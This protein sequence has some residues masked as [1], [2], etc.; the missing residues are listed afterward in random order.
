M[1]TGRGYYPADVVLLVYLLVTGIPLL[2]SPYSFPGRGDYMMMHFGGLL[3]VSL[4]HFAPRAGHPLWRFV[5]HWYIF[6][7]LPFL[8][9]ALRHLNRLLSLDFF[10][11]EVVRVEEAIFGCQPSQI[12]HQLLPFGSLSEFLHLSYLLYLALIP[13]VGFS[14]YYAGRRAAHREFATT[15]L[16]AYFTCYLLFILLPVR[17]PFHYFGPLDPPPVGGFFASLVHDMLHGASSVGTAFPSS[18]VAAAVAIWLVSR[19]HQP[20]ISKIVG[21][22][23]LGI[24]VG[25]VYGGF[26][27][28][29]DAAVGLLVGI[30]IGLLGP[31]LHGGLARLVD[32]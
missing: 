26:H 22:L 9:G 32:G 2:L 28:A 12:L 3:L 25:T 4:L 8:Y 20:V 14:L 31:R 27:Y 30:A 11:G 19:R 18:H 15:A 5:R 13:L 21:V 1:R 16:S 24:L 29:V 23:A 6:F 7:G 10:D 17:G